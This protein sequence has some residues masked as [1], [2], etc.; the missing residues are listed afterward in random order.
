MERYHWWRS[1]FWASERGGYSRGSPAKPT[2][3]CRCATT[4]PK[5]ATGP[6]Q[7]GIKRRSFLH[8]CVS[9]HLLLVEGIEWGGDP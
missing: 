9:C 7:P 5:L 8:G 3:P 2:Q 4:W 6:K 1:L